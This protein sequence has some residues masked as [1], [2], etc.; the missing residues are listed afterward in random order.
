MRIKQIAMADGSV[1]SFHYRDPMVHAIVSPEHKN[2]TPILAREILI[3]PVKRQG[4]W[5]LGDMLSQASIGS[6]FT[7]YNRAEAAVAARTA[8]KRA[9]SKAKAH[10]A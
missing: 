7:A 6:L 8:V 1:R 10:R 5:N 2:G 3:A 4:E 9:P